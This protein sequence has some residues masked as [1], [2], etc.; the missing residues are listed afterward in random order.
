M[1]PAA[2]ADARLW[3]TELGV[4]GVLT[5]MFIGRF[6]GLWRQYRAAPDE[7]LSGGPTAERQAA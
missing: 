2:F 6:A 7:G 1:D 3:L 4:S 5:G